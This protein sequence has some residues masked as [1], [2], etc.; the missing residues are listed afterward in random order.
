MIGARTQYL[1]S[2]NQTFVNRHTRLR[3]YAVKTS[4]P[5]NMALSS[6]DSENPRH[7]G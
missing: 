1:L 4:E 6:D 5:R 3:F 2:R 7:L